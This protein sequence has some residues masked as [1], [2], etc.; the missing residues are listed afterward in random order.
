MAHATDE[1]YKLKTSGTAIVEIYNGVYTNMRM[2]GYQNSKL[3][4]G[5]WKN[6]QRQ[7]IDITTRAI[8]NRFSDTGRIEAFDFMWKEGMENK[9]HIFWDS[10]V[11]KWMEAVAYILYNDY[12]PEFAQH[13]ETLIDKIENNQDEDGYFNVYFSVCEPEKRFMGRTNHELYC[14]GHL[15]EAAVAYYEATGKDRF[16]N[17][18]RKYA[19]YIYQVFVIERSAEFC[20]PGHEEIELALVRLYRCTRESKFLELAQYFI[21]ARGVQEEKT[22]DY[23]LNKYDQSHLPVRMQKTAEGHAVRACYLYTGMAYLAHETGDQELFE[24]CKK[25]FFDIIDKKMYITGGIGSTHIGEAFT[26]PYDLPNDVA[27]NET[28]ASIA[29]CLFARAM[30]EMDNNTAYADLIE[31]ELYNGMLA[32]ISLDSKA[33]FYENPLEINLRNYKR[34]TATKKKERYPITLRKEVFETSCCPP[35]IN[36]T[37]A[38]IQK[39]IYGIDENIVYINQFMS[40]EL[41]IEDIKI[42]MVTKY[43]NDGVVK[44]ESRNVTA[45]KIRIPHWCQEF[46][47]DCPYEIQGG[48]IYINQPENVIVEFVMK[49]MLM[50]SNPLIYRNN[51]KAAVQYG[52]IVYC[53]ESIYNEDNL[54]SL[55]IDTKAE[56]KAEY[57][58]EFK[59]HVLKTKGYRKMHSGKL[60]EPV[61]DQFESKEIIFIPYACHANRGETNMMVWTNVKQ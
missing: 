57:N 34:N 25:I 44:I 21:D 1:N 10:D 54:Y 16:L 51:G 19:D 40:S 53:M 29:M 22:Y 59:L 36:R 23:A 39:Y 31:K 50:E 11:A 41:N 43:P 38:S 49:P 13:V 56:I 28:C 32:G 47:V 46:K 6:K 14:A 52:P 48:Y 26:L 2:I 15:I 55:Y 30:M 5:F 8:F 7:N 33:F 4:D 3:M 42:R 20:T 61:S 9:P 45:M 24:A 37:I 18:M 60:Y 12:I 17:C 58:D 35:N 27:Y